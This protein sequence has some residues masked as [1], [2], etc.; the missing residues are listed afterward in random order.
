[1]AGERLDANMRMTIE[2]PDEL[3]TLEQVKALKSMKGAVLIV[4]CAD[5]TGLAITCDPKLP[6]T[7]LDLLSLRARLTGRT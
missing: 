5:G 6:T 2:I 3:I 7:R 1:M 4:E